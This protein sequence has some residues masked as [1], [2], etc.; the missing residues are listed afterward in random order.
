[1]QIFNRNRSASPMR[2]SLNFLGV[3]TYRH[4]HTPIILSISYNDLCN[5]YFSAKKS[6]LFF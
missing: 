1:M 3:Q 5:D 4:G 6:V 2:E